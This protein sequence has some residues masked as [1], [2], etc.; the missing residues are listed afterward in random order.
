ML[1]FGRLVYPEASNILKHYLYCN[2]DYLKIRSDYFK[3]SKFIKITLEKNDNEI[4]GPVTLKISDDPGIAYAVNGFYIKRDSNKI[5][6]FQD[7][8]FESINKR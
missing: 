8:S 6:I 3:R 1:F 2:G 4:I 5:V 7:I